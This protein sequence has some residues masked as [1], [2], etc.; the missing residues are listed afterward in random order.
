[1]ADNSDELQDIIFSQGFGGITDIEIGPDGYIYVLSLAE[2]GG[3]NCDDILYF[4]KNCISYTAPLEGTIFQIA[5]A[6]T[7]TE[8][9]EL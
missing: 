9:D 3:N 4:D 8:E 2:G 5:T 7:T 6:T 1:M